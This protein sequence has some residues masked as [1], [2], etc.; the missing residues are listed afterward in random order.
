M[1]SKIVI[2]LVSCLSLSSAMTINTYS[3][4]NC[5]VNAVNNVVDAADD[6]SN[7]IQNCGVT[8]EVTTILE[9]CDN[10]KEVGAKIVQLTN[11]S[12]KSSSSSDE[13]PTTQCVDDFDK[14][15]MQF[16]EDMKNAEESASKTMANS[17]SQMAAS[18]LKLKLDNNQDM[19]KTC[20]TM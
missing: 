11:N 19:G 18:K 4:L 7:E 8:A 10:L 9:D 13:V 12:C 2:L 3:Q 6:F 20:G 1:N 17:C 15:M 16:M 14:V 5:L